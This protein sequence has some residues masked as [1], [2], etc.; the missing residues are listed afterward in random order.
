[1]RIELVSTGTELL[2]GTTRNTHGTWVG[3]RLFKLGMRL[4]RHVTVP[5][6][7]AVKEAIREGME[8]AGVLL[9]TGGLGPTSDDLTREALGEVLGVRMVENEAAL[10]EI[11]DFFAQRGRRMAAGNR[12]Q[13]MAPEGATVLPNPNG[14][15]PGVFAPAELSGKR[16][17]AVFL[18]PGPPGE[19]YPMFEAE[20]VPRL[21]ELPG[22]RRTP[23]IVELKF[24]GIGESDFHEAIDAE[25]GEVEGLE[26]G[27]CARLGEVDLRL[28]GSREATAA[29]REIAERAFGRELVSDD[30]SSLEATVV[31]LLRRQGKTM[32]IAESC[33]GGL[34]GHRLTNVPG[35]SEVMGYGFVTYADKAKCALL[36]VREEDL[37]AHGAVSEPVARQMAEE[38]LRVAEADVAV[39]VTGIAGPSGGSDEK[40]V[41]TVFLAVARKDGATEVVRQMHPRERESFKWIVSQAALNMVRVAQ[42]SNLRESAGSFSRRQ[43]EEGSAGKSGSSGRS[44][45]NHCEAAGVKRDAEPGA[46]RP[47][48]T[49]RR[50]GEWAKPVFRPFGDDEEV[51]KR[52]R[53]LPHWDLPGATQFVTFR[54]SDSIPREGLERWESE[55]AEWLAMRGI[56]LQRKGEPAPVDE[57]TPEHRREYMQRFGDWFLDELDRG[58]GECVLRDPAN[59]EIVV[60]AL[61]FFDGQRYD[62]GDFVIMPN[63]VHLLVVLRDDNRLAEVLH[64]WK[65]HAARQINARMGRAGQLW[66]T[67]R[68]DH[69]VRSRQQLERLRDYIEYNPVKA[70]LKEGEYLHERREWVCEG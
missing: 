41:G 53:R 52:R 10:G 8:R 67:E 66:Q 49:A 58:H 47:E 33:T 51:R 56:D 60:E 15:A 59:A 65:R 29:G 50:P 39:A 21:K 22:R 43:G 1:M 25:L 5:D 62:L 35:A 46:R 4:E 17:C 31:K 27:Y 6:G 68:F 32:A 63:H 44:S 55:R 11:E 3:Q 70:N 13:A 34:I 23:E 40:P 57:L 28:I 24:V 26:V 61:R 20:V 2:L 69:I 12:K 64:S 37:A 54:L 38:A 18:L 7:E 45:S 19:M 9:V 36:G 14:T 16:N 42:V 30:G 48:G